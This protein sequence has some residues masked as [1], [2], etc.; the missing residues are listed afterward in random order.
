MKFNNL[1]LSAKEKISLIGNIS[2]M[3]S[4]GIPILEA[5]ESLLSE[6]KSNQEKIL[7]AMQSD[8]K[9]GKR[10]HVTFS[11]FPKVFSQVTVNLIKAAEESGTLETTLK[12]L[13]DSTQ[14]EMEFNDKIKSAMFYPLII[15]FVFILV[16]LT[17][18]IVVIPRISKVFKRLKV[19]LPLPTKILIVLSDLI[20]NNTLLV[21]GSILGICI[22]IYLLYHFKREVFIK[23]FSS[24]PVVSTLVRQID[25]SRFTRSLHLLL[26][27][28]IPIASALKLAE[29]VIVKDEVR[30]LVSKARTLALD[31]EKFSKGLRTKKNIFPSVMIKLMEVGESTGS[32]EESM[33]NISEYMDYEVVRSLNK[34]TI[35]LEP[36]M[37]VFVGLSVGGLMMAIIAPIYGLISQVG[38]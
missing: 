7:K 22:A 18:L 20:R 12:D 26:I 16:L 37:L 31:G 2:T 14:E 8:L 21:V 9:A 10:S 4:A 34:V 38:T 23:F 6:V 11:K 35:L 25:I 24:L 36:I 33:Q 27:S 32:L 19:E 1:R 28:G 15:I 3:L 5:V 13:K 17:I 29:D 30:K